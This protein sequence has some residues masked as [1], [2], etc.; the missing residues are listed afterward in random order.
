MTAILLPEGKQSFTTL[1]GVPLVGGKVFTWDTGTSNPRLTWADAAQTAPNTNPVILDARGEA[2]IFWNGAYRVQLQDSTGAIIWTVDGISTQAA[3]AISSLIPS[4]TNTFDLGSSAFTWRNL[5]LGPSGNAAVD[6]FGNLGLWVQ[7]SAEAVAGVTP[8][9]TLY[10]PGDVRRYGAIG[11]GAHDDTAAFTTAG[12]L[13]IGFAEASGY[14]WKLTAFV[15]GT[16]MSNGQLRFKGVG[17]VRYN[18]TSGSPF[19]DTDNGLKG[20]QFTSPSIVILGDSISE[21]S[22]ATTYKEG[23]SYSA[24]RSIW[25]YHKSAG[26]DRDQGY[27]YQTTVNLANALLEGGITTT[28][29]PIATGVVQSRIS[30]AAG[31]TITVTQR[32]MS[33]LDVIYDGA[34]SAGSVSFALNGAAAYATKAVAGAVLNSTFP[35]AIAGG[36]LCSEADSIVITAVGG[37]VVVTG[38]VCLRQSVNSPLVYVA[39]KSGTT[40]SDYTG[41]AA[42][43]ELAFY[44][45]FQK[46]GAEKLIV[47]ALGTNSIY[48]AGKT[49]TP[50]QMIASIDTLIAGIQAVCTSTRFLIWVPP[51]A[52]ES[53][54]PVINA[55]YTYGDYVKALVDYANP[56][57]TRNGVSLVRLDKS[58]LSTGLYYSDGLHPHSIGHRILC[59]AVL[60]VLRVPYNPTV[61]TA[62]LGTGYFPQCDI[63]PNSTWGALAGSAPLRGTSLRIG[64]H[65][66]LGGILQP[67]GAVSTTVGTLPVSM[68]PPYQITTT[69]RT[70]AGNIAVTINTNGT[71]VIPAVPATFFSL[72]GVSFTQVRP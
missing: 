10:P 50:A 19:D 67:N 43:T 48:N 44:L 58:I 22:F 32:Q 8:A 6:S 5:Y 36:A 16:F 69:G 59:Q 4:Q 42:I 14:L 17:Y 11:D 45:N 61:Q 51:R 55:T 9:N 18:T 21:G 3:L 60:D 53:T 37:T 20:I 41:A 25:N 7:T 23:W 24:A 64:P 65:V 28:G 56:P 31:Q 15:S 12:L 49:Q 34:A 30:L 72:D 2:V 40:Y 47:L 29:T 63:L 62:P 33:Y 35:T 57:A 26:F 68:R 38:L 54:F 66:F 27:G 13:G 39:A 52:N 71:I 46:A 70:D 1:A